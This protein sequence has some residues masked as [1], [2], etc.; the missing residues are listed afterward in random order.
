MAERKYFTVV[1]NYFWV[2]DLCKN[3][4]HEITH[5]QI[6]T[7]F[8]I[9]FVEDH[10]ASECNQGL[11]KGPWKLKNLWI[12]VFLTTPLPSKPLHSSPSFHSLRAIKTRENLNTRK[13]WLRMV[14][15]KFRFSTV[16]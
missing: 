5:M 11:A 16:F 3:L 12:T 14:N 10:R 9:Q 15:A 4:S 7:T 13:V 1:L 2:M 6:H 8:C